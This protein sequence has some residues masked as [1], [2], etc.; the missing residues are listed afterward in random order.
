MR[1][2]KKNQKKRTTRK[3]RTSSS[4]IATE[5]KLFKA[6]QSYLEQVREVV[7][8]S[9]LPRIEDLAKSQNQIDQAIVNMDS[10]D[11]SLMALYEGMKSK[12]KNIKPKPEVMAQL[13]AVQESLQSTVTKQQGQLFEV[14]NSATMTKAEAKKAMV[15][16][17]PV[18][19]KVLDESI[20]KNFNLMK[21]ISEETLDQVLKELQSGFSQSKRWEQVA[22]E[23][24]STIPNSERGVWA[25]GKNRAKF[26]ARNEVGNAL[27]EMNKAVQ[28]DA[29]FRFYKWQTSEDDRVRDTHTELNGQVFTWSGMEETV[30]LE[31]G[32]TFT[33]GGAIDPLYSGSP[34]IPS[35]PYNCR[36]VAVAFDPE[37][38]L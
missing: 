32:S 26:V 13:E 8:E 36:C 6:F 37:I 3:R 18:A 33:A 20:G 9:L 27:G 12:V 21:V 35:E 22:K 28:S 11:K 30:T 38:D 2:K 14:A 25:S 15:R 1:R 4:Q 34:V 5:R 16:Q 7:L 19:S 17:N 23:M 24:K 10:N 29:G 31:D